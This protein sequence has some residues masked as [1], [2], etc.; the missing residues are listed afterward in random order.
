MN[1]NFNVDYNTDTQELKIDGV[2]KGKYN[3]R[4]AKEYVADYLFSKIRRVELD[5]IIRNAIAN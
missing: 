2:S 3:E 1:I 5:N 4:K